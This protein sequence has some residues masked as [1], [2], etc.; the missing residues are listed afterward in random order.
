VDAVKPHFLEANPQRLAHRGR[1]VAPVP[2]RLVADVNPI[3]R[4]LPG[5]VNV[6]RAV[7][8]VP[9]LGLDCPDVLAA[10][11]RALPRQPLILPLQRDRAG[12][13]ADEPGDVGVVQPADIV[14]QLRLR[15]RP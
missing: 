4:V 10:A 5:L 7:A 13:H 6:Q 2:D 11:R 15:H 8:D 9:P 1:A 12:L 3:T 14:R